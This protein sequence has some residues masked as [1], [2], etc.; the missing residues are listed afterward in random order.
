MTD[1]Q[2]PE[3]LRIA[4]LL[5]KTGA[6]GSLRDEAASELRRLH[7][8]LETLRAKL[9]TYEDLGDAADD[10]QLLRMGYA[11][12]RLEIESLK[13]QSAAQRWNPM[14]NGNSETALQ[15]AAVIAH[16]DAALHEEVYGSIMGAAYDFRDAHISGSMN[17][18]RSAHAELETAVRN[19][20]RASHGQAP[21]Q[22][23]APAQAGE[24]PALVCDYC[25]AL[26]PDPWHSSG[27]LHGRMSKHIHSCD[28]CCRGA[29]QAAPAAVAG[30]SDPSITLDFKQATELLKMFG[31]E[32]GLV[33]LQHGNERSHS[34]AGLYA[35][36]SDLP[37]EGAVFLGA[38]PDDEAAP[39]AQPATQQEAQ[40][41]AAWKLA[42]ENL[43]RENAALRELSVTNIML[44]VV[45]GDGSGYEV[46]AK[47]VSDVV[48]TLTRLGTEL[49]EWQLGIKRLPAL[50]GIAPVPSKEYA[51]LPLAKYY[52]AGGT[53]EVWS[54][55]QMRAFADATHALRV[56]S[57]AAAYREEL[58][59]LS[60]R[61][62]ELRL[63]SHGQ[64][65]AGAASVT[66]AMVLAALQV[67]YPAGYGTQLRHPANG[68]KTS[69]RTEAEIDLARRMIAAALATQPAPQQEAQEPAAVV[70]PCHTPSGKRVALYSAKQ[71]LP[72]GTKLYTSP[73]PSPAARGDALESEYRRGYRHGYEQRD[74]EVRGALA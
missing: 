29:A 41:P 51:E 39:T 43:Q 25:G 67:Q 7:D 15:M 14:E 62:Y 40:E 64:A 61:N 68:P 21:A 42:A 10:M 47:N 32:P 8:E 19:A 66:D 24:Y 31:G 17:L 22:A 59:K 4:A 27:M 9:K 3:P 18:K 70:V 2:Q 6:K 36:Y 65:P 53:V 74:A 30:P 45:P 28:A 11:A 5:E 38:E 20:I 54:A 58:D 34:G 23:A 55:D 16:R 44:D 52:L 73:Q 60:K 49:E 46:Y 1:K 63:A 12:A 48:D 72:I 57:L 37:E 56:E 71:D 13:S 35:W 50:A 69:E 33:T 26:T